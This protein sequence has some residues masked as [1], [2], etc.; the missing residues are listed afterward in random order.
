ME[1]G[2]K[3]APF[4]VLKAVTE[5]PQGLEAVTVISP[6]GKELLKETLI[7]LLPCPLMSVA[8]AGTVQVKVI[9]LWLTTE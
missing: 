8:P 6:P 7:L 2:D 5:T 3:G 4:T 9:P 1:P